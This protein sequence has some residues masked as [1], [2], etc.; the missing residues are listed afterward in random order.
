MKLLL[1]SI[2]AI[3]LVGCASI[4]VQPPV[5]NTIEKSKNYS[6]SYEKAWVRAVD[7]FADHNVTIEKIEKSSGLLTAKYLIEA[8]DEF[9]DCGDIKATGTL[10]NPVIEKYGSLNVTIREKNENTTKVN[11]NFFGEFTL[12]ANDAWDGHL[13]KTKGRC[14]STGKLE[15]NILTYIGN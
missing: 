9:L 4:K 11:V 7:W 10:G 12:Q 1:S 6:I 14:V 5:K 3:I 13:V 15:N 2:I 8:N